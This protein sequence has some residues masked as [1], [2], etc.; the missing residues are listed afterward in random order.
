MYGWP[1][2]TNKRL[3]W[4]SMRNTRNSCVLPMLMFGDFNE[5]LGMHEKDGGATRGES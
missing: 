2:A 4:E 1:K 5:I 3:T